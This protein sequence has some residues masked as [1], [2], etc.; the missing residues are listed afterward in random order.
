MTA[1]LLRFAIE[2]KQR[3]L[4]TPRRSCCRLSSQIRRSGGDSNKGP[5]VHSDACGGG[6]VSLQR[7]RLDKEGSRGWRK[8]VCVVPCN[9]DNWSIIAATVGT[10]T[11]PAMS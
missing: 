11:L 3:H 10:D 5:W 2:Y 4:Q 8:T 1:L 7:P 9:P 6:V